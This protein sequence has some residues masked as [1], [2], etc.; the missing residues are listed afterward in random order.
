MKM[1]QTMDITTLISTILEVV[2]KFVGKDLDEESLHYSRFI[3]HLKYLTQR[4]LTKE[5]IDSDDIQFTELVLNRYPEEYVCSQMIA[6]LI[7]E[8][9]LYKIT[10]E[11]LLYLTVHIKR[12]RKSTK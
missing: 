11:E 2:R 7:E 10:R 4:I 6:K 1:S 3:T 5:N 8:K 9:Y 12:V